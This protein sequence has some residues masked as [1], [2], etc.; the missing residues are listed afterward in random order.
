MFGYSSK[1]FI[2]SLNNDNGSGHAVYNPVKLQVRSHSHS[3]AVYL[4]ASTGPIFGSGDIY[5]SNYS[6]SNQDS[7]TRCRQSY[8]LPSRR[9]FILSLSLFSAPLHI[10]CWRVSLHPNKY[11]SFLRNNHLK[12]CMT[13]RR[14]LKQRRFWTTHAIPE[15][16]FCQNFQLNSLY[17]CKETKR[18]KFYSVKA[19]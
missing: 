2:Y 8:P 15:Q 1:A 9:F 17:R 18:Y 6:A 10:L 12:G 13:W 3:Y 7:F 11:R 4:C 19:Y 5:I 14:E 16:W